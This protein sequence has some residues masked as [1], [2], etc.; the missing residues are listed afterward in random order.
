MDSGCVCFPACDLERGRTTA[1]RN[2]NVV[3]REKMVICLGD[4]VNN[5]Y[6]T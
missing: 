1:F 6:D 5:I 3:L 4:T 2:R